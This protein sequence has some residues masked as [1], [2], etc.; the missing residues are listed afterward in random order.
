[1]ALSSDQ[2]AAPTSQEEQD[3]IV[4][5]A[6]QVISQVLRGGVLLSAGVIALGLLLLILHRPTSD[7]FPHTLLAVGKSLAQGNPYGIIVLGLLILLFTPVLRVAVSI[8]AFGLE[9]DRRFVAISAIELILLL[10]SIV[11]LGT[12]FGNN[13]AEQSA[14]FNLGFFFLVFITSVVAGLVGSLVGLGGGVF[15]V[16]ILTLAFGLPID[17][18]VGASI[19]SVIATSSG[20]AA[21][22]VHDRLSNMRI[23]NLLALA[24][25]LG[26]ISGALLAAIFAPRLLFII[27]G[28]VLLASAVPLFI[29]IGE[30][31]PRDVTNDRWSER[32]SLASS[33]HDPQK[34]GDVP[35]AVTH[36][37]LGFGMMYL[38]GII[39]GLLGIG[40]GSFKVVAMDNAMR[41]P[42]KVSS[43]TSN[44][45]IG[46][47][48]AAS[49]G[50]YFQRGFIFPLVAAPVA[51]G[52][53]IG[54]L[55]GAKTLARL[56]NST[57]R[58]LFVPILVIVAVEMLIRGITVH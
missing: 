12:I 18:A 35:Y 4:R 42:M 3:Q 21:A 28:L 8:V 9:R 43:T 34:G 44:F 38:A 57:I 25:I 53:L 32:L 22:F 40:S 5:R 19:V 27:F 36:V 11:V 49:A 14:R 48:A 58:K 6:N 29:K 13:T 47:T 52:V 16:P 33:Y 41:L 23:G 7:T 39:S 46:V 50:I 24:T 56:S 51:L 55:V 37:P 26:A 20:A 15:V 54:A 17:I 45:M 30:E 1:M 10:L 2:T 31:L